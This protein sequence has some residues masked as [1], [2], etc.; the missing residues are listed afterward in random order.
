MTAPGI[1]FELSKPTFLKLQ[2]ALAEK[3]NARA[4]LTCFVKIFV[5]EKEKNENSKLLIHLLVLDHIATPQMIPDLK[6]CTYVATHFCF[7]HETIYRSANLK[8]EKTR[9]MVKAATVRMY[10]NLFRIVSDPDFV[11]MSFSNFCK[12]LMS[13]TIFYNYDTPQ[14]EF[15]A[16][17]YNGGISRIITEK[18]KHVN[19]GLPK[20]KKTNLKFF[21]H[22]AASFLPLPEYVETY[23]KP[24]Y[25]KC[26]EQFCDDIENP[27]PMHIGWANINHI[28]Y[29]FGVQVNKKSSYGS[30]LMT[31]TLHAITDEDFDLIFNSFEPQISI[32]LFAYTIF[33]S[34]KYFFPQYPSRIKESNVQSYLKKRKKQIFVSLFAE[35]AG[36]IATAYCGCFEDYSEACEE[37]KPRICRSRVH[38]GVVTVDASKHKG[39]EPAAGSIMKDAQILYLNPGFLLSDNEIRLCTDVVTEYPKC[40]QIEQAVANALV[41]FIRNFSNRKIEIEERYFPEIVDKLWE[42]SK[43]CKTELCIPVDTAGRIRME[44]FEYLT[45]KEDLLK[46]S[47]KTFSKLEEVTGFLHPYR[48]H[49]YAIE[50]KRRKDEATQELLMQNSYNKGNG[51]QKNIILPKYMYLMASMKLF[52]EFL[53]TKTSVSPAKIEYLDALVVDVFR[54]MSLGSKTAEIFFNEYISE[55]IICDNIL[56]VRSPGCDDATGWYDSKGIIYL[57]NRQYFKDIKAYFAK[58]SQVFNYTKKEFADELVK[59]KI[60]ITH[61][62]SISDGQVRTDHN[63]VV[64]PAGVGKMKG[65]SVIKIDISAL[66]LSEEAAEKLALMSECSFAK[67][68]KSRN[69]EK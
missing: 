28:D 51:G 43:E 57:R 6:K 30:I 20:P 44:E 22:G 37:I 4:L 3:R 67:R 14:I 21:C 33:S 68:S 29:C 32:T 5:E 41:L 62:N 9:E 42:I 56:P 69:V 49:E 45:T 53:K 35:E 15:L 26:E 2:S 38:D 66:S 19:K 61:L 48:K 60:L 17:E 34:I 10:G 58:R 36:Y 54:K 55:Q 13:G 25:V 59:K 16:L 31:Q 39:T 27:L 46:F 50:I 65:I 52:C 40:K 24:A 63:I 8:E 12:K 1:N 23:I 7:E 64:S 47:P 18:R 11:E